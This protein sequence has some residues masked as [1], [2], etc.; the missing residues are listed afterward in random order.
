MRL[1]HGGQLVKRSLAESEDCGGFCAVG[2]IYHAYTLRGM[3][4]GEVVLVGRLAIGWSGV[5]IM[6]SFEKFPVGGYGICG[7]G[8]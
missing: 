2:S 7:F 5:V 8:V 4:R 3:G 1:V 6:M